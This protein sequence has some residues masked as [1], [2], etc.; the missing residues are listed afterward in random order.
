MPPTILIN[1]YLSSRNQQ[2][3][4]EVLSYYSMLMYSRRA[5]A[6]NILISSRP[7]KSFAKCSPN[8]PKIEPRWIQK[9]F[10]RRSWTH[11]WKKID[12]ERPQ[13]GQEAPGSAPK[14]PQTVPNPSQIEPKTF[15]N[16]I[17]GWFFGIYYHISNS[18]CF[19]MD[20]LPFFL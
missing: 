14:M 2:N 13:N 1:Q 7:R 17:S 5:P 19:S 18:L 11:V 10:W 8:L 3:R 20:F 15:S 12:F 9:A 16:P 4:T 6:W